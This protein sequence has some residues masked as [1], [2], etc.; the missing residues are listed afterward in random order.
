MTYRVIKDFCDLQDDRHIYRAG[1]KYPRD[2]KRLNKKR[3]EEL[4]TVNN[5]QGTPLI[6]ADESM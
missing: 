3:A 6:V 5:R 1:D 2:G 4:S